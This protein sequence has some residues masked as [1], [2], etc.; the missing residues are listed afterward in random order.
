M[1]LVLAVA[2]L[3]L[4][5][6]FTAAS[7]ATM[8]LRVSSTVSNKSVAE[9]LA[10]SVVEQAMANLQ[11]DLGTDDSVDID[12]KSLGL[13]DGSRGYLTFDNR[14]GVPYSTNNFLGDRPNGWKRTL[15]E[16]TA[17]LVGVGECGG[18]TRH[19]EVVLHLPEFPVVMGCDGPVTVEN[20]FI[21]G[22]N[23]DDDRE[24]VPGDGYS[25][26]DDEIGPGH[27]V[28]NS[29]SATSIVLDRR[30]KITGDLQSLGNVV[31]NG[32]RVEGEVRA[33]WGKPAPLPDFTLTDFDP[34]TDE[35]LYY[36][37]IPSSAG[38]LTLV[39]NV[40]REGSLDLSGDLTLNNAF[41]YLE[42]DL[43]VRGNLRGQGAIVALGEVKFEGT[44]DLQSGDQLAVLSGRGIDVV[45][46]DP[47]RSV[48][49]GLLYTQGPFR[50]EKITI[51]G[52]FVVDNGA[53]TE[54]V[55]SNVFFSGVNIAPAQK[56]ETF[57]AIPRF[58]VPNFGIPENT[59]RVD[60]LGAPFG[61]WKFAPTTLERTTSNV[62]NVDVDDY[63]VSDWQLTDPAILRL[64]WV[65]DEP[66][67]RYYWR[68]SGD[69][70]GILP[71]DKPYWTDIEEAAEYLAAENTGENFATTG[72]TDVLGNLNGPP[73][74]KAQYKAYIISILNHLKQLNHPSGNYNFALDPN[75]FVGDDEELRVLLHRTF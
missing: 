67:I 7:V 42:G 9:S 28:T 17:Q 40:R 75:E 27:L 50:A 6:A 45:G 36:D 18:G 73:P 33:P 19:V 26:E 1:G 39:G 58:V 57:A 65:G 2:A 31:L 25:V 43:T 13:P 16:S 71:R 5:A 35:D 41:V 54:V 8:N 59:F 62:V 29:N 4:L 64:T 74:D 63:Q 46:R 70:L 12:G 22:F 55:D 48:F 20:S 14:S 21:G 66:Q 11:E 56:R 69:V 38:S 53:P 30:S 51:V 24:W 68:G 60:E 52:G 32:A 15:P 47:T 3:A 61:R 23:P 34:A 10:Q 72:S 44:V 49:Q 37:E